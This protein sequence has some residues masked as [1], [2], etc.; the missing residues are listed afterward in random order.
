MKRLRLS[1]AIGDYD[2]V[3]P[4]TDGRARIDGVD[5]VFMYLEPEEIFFRAFRQEAFDVCELSLSTFAL[6]TA[7]GNCAYVGV[8]VFP[9]RSFRHSA[10]YVNTTKG[11]ATPADLRGRRVGLPEWQ[12]TAC[13]WA[14]AILWDDHGVDPS[15]IRWVQ[16]GQEEPGRIEKA[17]FNLPEGVRI[18]AAPKG[19]TLSAMLAEGEID[20]L[21]APRA[22]SCFLRGEP[23]V[24]WLFSDPQAAASDWF[25][26]TGIF[27]IMHLLGVRR[28]LVDRQPWLPMALLKAF[29]KAKQLAISALADPAA[30]KVTLPFLDEQVR[31]VQSLM[32]RD[33]WPYGLEKNRATLE[34]FLRHHHRQGLSPRSLSAEELFHPSVTESF[35]I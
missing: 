25:A 6:S 32:G 10:I 2:R 5:P 35:K 21:I 19:K 28:S 23:S 8:P 13:V 18:E 33:Y 12:L 17:S 31:A 14:R 1:V 29:D 24:A 30:P 4:L 11:I 34:F 7:A 16:G 9:S 20:A 26:R 22:P 27:P 3:H 15:Q